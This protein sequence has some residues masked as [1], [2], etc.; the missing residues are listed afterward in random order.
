[1]TVPGQR[2]AFPSGYSRW[3]L[4]GDAGKTTGD[5]QEPAGG[6]SQPLRR[7]R[8]PMGGPPVEQDGPVQILH[9]TVG[10]V[11]VTERALRTTEFMTG[12]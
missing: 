4:S 9:G 8:T 1:M 7:P 12:W 11:P 5:A 6:H 3:G 2:R 10:D